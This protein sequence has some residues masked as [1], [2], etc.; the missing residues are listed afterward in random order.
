MR[1]RL[2]AE[3]LRKFV[4]ELLMAVVDTSGSSV[5]RVSSVSLDSRSRFLLE[6][7]VVVVKGRFCRGLSRAMFSVGE[8]RR[9][10]R[11][12]ERDGLVPSSR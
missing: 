4:V 1:Q 5:R 12:C 7:M 3:T 11:H 6:V 10:S 2:Q 9:R 8:M